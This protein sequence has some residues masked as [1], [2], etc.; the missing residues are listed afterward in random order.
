VT[1]T[2][3]WLLR[4]EAGLAPCACG[5]RRRRGGFAARTVAAAS[6]LVQRA[7]SSEE[8]AARPGLL[9]AVEP[10]VKLVTTAALLLAVGLVRHLPV[11]AALDLAV[12][13]LAAASRI[14]LG[15]FVKRVWLVVPLFTAAVA[16]PATLGFVTPGRVVV[17]LGTWF[18]HPAGITSQGLTAAGLIVCRVAASVS[19]VALVTLTT[20]WNRLLAALRALA[21]PRLFV[22]VLGMTCRYLLHL[23]AS[24]TDMYTARRSRT[25]GGGAGGAADRRFV[26][27]SAGALFGKAQ[28]LADEVHQAMVS[29]G[30]TG[31][32][33]TL[34]PAAV[35]T[36]DGLWAL[37]CLV[38][39][40]VTIGVD[41][42]LG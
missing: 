22:A 37:A 26:A 23:A 15:T 35:G 19:L 16:V 40:V 10:R 3:D 29:R 18:G 24:V 38:T 27:A 28:A 14:P 41:H 7:L 36:A 31:D 25:V 13:V 33:R 1:T 8:A 2:P 30:F 32:V 17:P 21:V 12:L 42:A 5:G 20:P 9:Q 34:A 39:V 11:L 6:G 4:P